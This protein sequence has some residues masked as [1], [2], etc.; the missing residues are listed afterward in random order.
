MLEHDH[1]VV[2]EFLDGQGLGN[3]LWN[4][5]SG[6]SIAK[7]SGRNLLVLNQ[8][9]F[10]G[11]N[12]LSLKNTTYIKSLP[13]N[14]THYHEKNFFNKKMKYIDS[15]YDEIPEKITG[16][17]KITGIFQ[18][19]RYLEEDILDNLVMR[20]RPNAIPGL[21][22]LNIRGREYKRKK[23]FN[24]KK[25]YWDD[26]LNYA[27]QRYEIKNVEIVTDDKQYARKLFPD[28]PIISESIENCFNRL[29]QADVAI[30]SNS[31]FGYFPTRL[32]SCKKIIAPAYFARHNLNSEWCSMAN[33]YLNYTYLDKNSN[34][35][36]Y[37]IEREK[38]LAKENKLKFADLALVEKS[39]VMDSFFKKFIPSRVLKYL[40]RVL[41]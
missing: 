36:N 17:I 10:K 26:A 25:K 27:Q 16:D 19:E 24:L 20:S 3:Q 34:E 18:D 12:F 40:R 38:I 11:R 8:E 41:S 7:R 39:Y 37:S 31:T 22:I 13:K 1:S 9:N 32:S 30:L 33:F 14:V 6:L 5:A 15:G 2:V 29:Y 35:V 21:C 28:I 23:L 4:W